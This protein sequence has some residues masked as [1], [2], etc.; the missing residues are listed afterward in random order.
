MM[1]GKKLI[2]NA[3]DFGL[4][5]G[6]NQAILASYKA[7]AVSSTTLM[8]NMPAVAEAA[9]LAHDHPKLGVG[10]HF[11][12]TCGRPVAERT[13]VSSLIG[14]D[15]TFL[16]RGAAEKAAVA[17][18]FK[19]QHLRRELEAQ[20]QRLLDLGVVPTHIDSHQHIHVF[21]PI[22]DV[23]AAFC[24]Q[25]DIPLRIP[26]VWRPSVGLP[27]KR[28][29]RSWML[30][31]ML[32]RNTNRWQGQLRCNAA[33]AS[34]FDLQIAVS[35]IRLENYL[36]ILKVE[37]PEPLELMVHPAIVDAGHLQ[38]TGISE[39]S[40]ADYRILANEPFAAALDRLGYQLVSYAE[41]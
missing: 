37:H 27:L 17:G 18:R 22:F 2:I 9:L 5:P 30:S 36:D 8:V 19:P 24:R 12:L 21:P 35:E 6:T 13:E 16:P 41:L 26:W 40:N 15:E 25:Y 28:R 3:D 20:W 38:L 1:R 11:N 7:G 29:L 34:I 31:W 39:T 10:L 14:P 4:S 33:F 23:V 32:R